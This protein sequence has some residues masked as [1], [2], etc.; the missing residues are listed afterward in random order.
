MIERNC[1]LPAELWVTGK[2]RVAS[3]QPP[4]RVVPTAWASKDGY[5]FYGKAN[6]AGREFLY[7]ISE[8]Y[9]TEVEANEVARRWANRIEG[10]ACQD[11]ESKLKRINKV[12]RALIGEA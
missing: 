4:M 5:C 8:A 11:F 9:L 10:Q 1:T 3:G 12:R 6:G 2:Q 7:T